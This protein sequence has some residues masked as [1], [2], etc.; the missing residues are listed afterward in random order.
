MVMSQPDSSRRLIRAI[1]RFGVRLMTIPFHVRW[2]EAPE[3]GR[4]FG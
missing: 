2:K 3:V 4:Q 1:Q